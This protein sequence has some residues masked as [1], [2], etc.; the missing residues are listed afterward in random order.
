MNYILYGN[1][2]SI[3]GIYGTSIQL[4]QTCLLLNWDQDKKSSS[5]EE[6]HTSFVEVNTNGLI[7]DFLRIDFVKSHISYI[8]KRKDLSGSGLIFD[9]RSDPN[10][11]N[12]FYSIYSKARIQQSLSQNQVTIRTLLNSNKES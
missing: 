8:R 11:I 12:P 1:G 9:D 10:N 7:R 3:R 5:V 4:V 2:K 6:A